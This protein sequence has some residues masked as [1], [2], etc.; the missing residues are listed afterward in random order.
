MAAKISS[1]YGYLDM[2]GR[3]DENNF[4]D[5]EQVAEFDLW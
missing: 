1:D 4:D 3:R 2:T 5:L